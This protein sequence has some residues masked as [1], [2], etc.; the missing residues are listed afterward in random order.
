MTNFTARTDTHKNK[1][2]VQSEDKGALTHFCWQL[3]TNSN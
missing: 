2:R 3:L 1:E